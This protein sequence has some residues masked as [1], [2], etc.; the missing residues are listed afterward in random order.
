MTR[1]GREPAAELA[2]PSSLR[3]LRGR[4]TFSRAS[5]PTR[6]CR[7][8]SGTA[9]LGH[10]RA[11]RPLPRRPNPARYRRLVHGRGGAAGITVAGAKT[12]THRARL[13]LRKF[14]ASVSPASCQAKP[15]PWSRHL[16][17][18]AWSHWCEPGSWDL[19]RRC[20]RNLA[21]AAN[22]QGAGL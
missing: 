10:W 8:N 7:P 4:H 18:K 21:D 3:W 19:G 9:W 11:T 2:N 1:S 6:L 14:S 20:G 15:L 5:S 13:F 17:S 16:I 12:R 22:P